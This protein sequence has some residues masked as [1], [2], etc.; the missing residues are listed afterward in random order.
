[1]AP[2]DKWPWAQFVLGELARVPWT[3]WR[4]QIDGLF[5]NANRLQLTKAG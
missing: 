5:A 1:L 2:P 3:A 4:Q